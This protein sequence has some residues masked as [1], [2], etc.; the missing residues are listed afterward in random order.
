MTDAA[1]AD[2]SA[3][4]IEPLPANPSLDMQRKRA[5]ALARDYWRGEAETTARVRALHPKPPAAADFKLS[6]AQLVI[7]RGYG[8][9][10]WAR[11][12]SKIDGLT[13]SPAELF[14]AAV[15][16]GD[17]D[18][19]RALLQAHP[20][21]VQRINEPLFDFKQT[22]AHAAARNLPLLDLLI[23]HGADLNIR[24]SWEQG[25]FGILES[26]TPEQAAPLIA[27]GARVDVWA[28]ANL[29]MLDELKALL[30]ADPALVNAGGGD[31][32]RP[33]HYAKSVEIATL[34]LDRGADIDAL[35]DD[36]SST[37]AQYLVSDAPEV[38]K[39]L[40]QRGA[41][42]DL[43][44]AAALGDVARVARHLDE[45]PAAIAM[46]VSRDWFPMIDT[47]PNGG[48]IYQWVLGFHVS[49]FD[50]ARKHGHQAVLDVLTARA[51]PMQRLLDAL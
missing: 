47:A 35:D 33:L 37:P 21:V 36:H 14:V 28:A 31:G 9:A 39:F 34:L 43:L 41:R 10:S 48:H 45:N 23:A 20:D 38:C 7:A 2:G 11:L 50:L 44:M 22:A 3:R 8:F 51:G 30:D 25:G 27:R 6:D 32:K 46:R 16:A 12:K 17:I 42:S 24:S 5:K 15:K 18:G 26:V 29:G 13:R 40:L 1:P 4:F 19:V 49:A